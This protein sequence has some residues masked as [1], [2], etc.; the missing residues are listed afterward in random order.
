MF[1]VLLLAIVALVAPS[2]AVRSLRAR[3]QAGQKVA[4][5][6]QVKKTGA[7]RLARVNRAVA[8]SEYREASPSERRFWATEWSKLQSELLKLEKAAGGEGYQPRAVSISELQLTCNRHKNGT[9]NATKPAASPTKELE[10]KKA[11]ATKVSDRMAEAVAA[12]KAGALAGKDAKAALAPMLGMLKEVY[13]DAKSRIAKMNAQE[14]KAKEKFAKEEAHHK[15]RIADIEARYKNH[16]IS[17]EFYKNETRDEDRIFSYFK[18]SRDLQHKQFHNMLK[19]NHGTMDREKGMIKTYENAIAGKPPPK[20]EMHKL[21]EEAPEVVFLQT[22][23]KAVLQFVK[24]SLVEV[25]RELR[26]LT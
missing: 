11:N 9:K 18:R 24:E 4:A 20:A 6:L 25:R 19:L 3:E 10:S 1:R 22:Q 17:E 13:G 21:Q 12:A 15:A 5:K 14:K 23:Q 7:G 16:S 2:W 26:Y 8:S